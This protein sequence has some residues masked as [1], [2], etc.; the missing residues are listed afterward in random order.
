MGNHTN[1]GIEK[2]GGKQVCEE[3][4]SAALNL[5]EISGQAEARGSPPAAISFFSRKSGLVILYHVQATI[6]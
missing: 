6:E 3:R 5:K 1:R 4:R 2:L